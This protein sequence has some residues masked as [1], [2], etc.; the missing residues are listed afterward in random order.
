M[1][2]MLPPVPLL[3]RIV[4]RLRTVVLLA[5]AAVSPVAA[6]AGMARVTP[7]PTLGDG[8]LIALGIVL[9]GTGVA[10]LRK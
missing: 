5:V 9:V 7:A 1:I 6:W 4:M 10:F 2:G 3:R 8:G